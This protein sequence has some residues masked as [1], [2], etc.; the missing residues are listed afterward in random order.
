MKKVSVYLLRDNLAK[1]LDEV[2]E[3]NIPLVICKYDKPVAIINPY[4]EKKTT[5][6]FR[7]R[8]YGFL[9]GKETGEEYL[10]RVRRSPAEKKYAKL[11]RKGIIKRPKLVR[12]SK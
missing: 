6:D 8:Y 7:K 12:K 9:G 3:N 2:V 10:N 11:L 5:S 4:Q 1:Y